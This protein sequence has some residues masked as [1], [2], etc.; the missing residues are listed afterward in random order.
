M[1]K[2]VR[3]LA[4]FFGMAALSGT[5][6]TLTLMYQSVGSSIDRGMARLG[7]D[8]MVVPLRWQGE[9]REILLSGQPSEFYMKAGVLEGIKGVKGVSDTAAQLFIVSAPLSCCT[10]SDTMLIGFDPDGDFTIT[11]WLKETLEKELSDI[12]V[13]VGAGIL[14]GQG[15]RIRFYGREFLVAGKLE[16][17][18][19]KFIDSAVFIPMKGARRMIAESGEKALKTLHIGQDEISAVLVRFDKNASHEEAAL[20]IE[21]ALPEVKVVLASEILRTARRNLLVPAK[22]VVT[23]GIIQWAVSLFMIGVL[24]SL[25]LGEREKETGL[26]RAMGAKKRSILSIFVYEV[27]LLSGTGGLAGITCGLIFILSFKNMLRIFFEVP[28][29]FP[30]PGQVLLIALTI[31]LFTLVSGLAA[32]FYPI[33][34]ASGKGSQTPFYSSI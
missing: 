2:P 5:L 4:I 18:G 7:A 30:S 33:I 6:F 11:P 24:Y 34:R 15:G 19:M 10:V 14:A 9:T 27:L 28:F 22:T 25:S 13:I 16:P 8:A 32:T 23:A 20:R 12:E 26:L 3:T 31:L 21:H 1:R 29:L 17:T